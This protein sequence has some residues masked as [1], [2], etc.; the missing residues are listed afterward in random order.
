MLL[1]CII[2][3]HLDIAHHF[4][5][6]YANMANVNKK[7]F[8]I[9]IKSQRLKFKAQSYEFYRHLETKQTKN[10]RPLV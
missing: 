6:R 9:I 4:D 10:Y 3:I 2:K 1:S 5:Y 7:G 8:L